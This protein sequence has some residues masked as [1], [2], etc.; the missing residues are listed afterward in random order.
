[1]K[2]AVFAYSRQG[3]K[4]ARRI[5]SYF[6]ED[7]LRGYTVER[8]AE[9]GFQPVGK[10]E[11]DFYGNCFAWADALIFVG[12]CGIAVRQIAPHIRDKRTDPAVVAI[13]ELA[14]FVIPLL[15]GHIGGANDLSLALAAHLGATAAVT[16][17][18]DINGRFAV[19]AWA[20]KHG[21]IIDRMDRA[22]AV[23]AAILEKDVAFC[24]DFPVAT[25]YPNGVVA[26]DSGEVGIYL[27]YRRREPFRQTLRLIPPVL[28]IG[29][30]CRR[31]AS[32][33]TIAQAVEQTLEQH[34][35]DIRGVRQAASIDLK[36]GEQGLL[37]YCRQKGW[38]LTFYSAEQLR[39]V[40]GSFS[41][42]AFVQ[43]VA[44]VDTVCE[45]AAMVDAGRLIVPK[46][47]MQGVTVAIAAENMEVYF[48]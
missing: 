34:A 9:P 38:P 19:D 22:K 44:G 5:F 43:T 8:L 21:Y 20:A 11:K 4:T 3:C 28:H 47:A 32:A 29:I 45:R 16:T 10:P 31:G 27:G 26:G 7:T 39:Q 46:T 33:E 23:S 36:A 6:A 24:S 2:V 35:I 18:T 25:A 1:M 14:R 12:A 42:S 41:S 48:G 37:D 30:G 40:E 17:A 15:A 13:D